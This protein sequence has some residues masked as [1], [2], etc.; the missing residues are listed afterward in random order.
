[1]KNKQTDLNDHLF[2]QMERLN[3]E[4]LSSEKLNFE[5]ERAKGM[6]MIAKEIIANQKLALDAQELLNNGDINQKP[7]IIPMFKGI[8]NASQIHN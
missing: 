5:I 1:M 7:G 8:K 4:G 6:T 3:E 2:M